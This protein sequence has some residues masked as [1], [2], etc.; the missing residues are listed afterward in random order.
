MFLVGSTI[1]HSAACTINDICDRDFDRQVGGW[2]PVSFNR[3][4]YQEQRRAHE[5]PPA[6]CWHHLRAWSYY[7]PHSSSR[8]VLLYSVTGEQYRVS[9]CVHQKVSS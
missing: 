6:C 1:L 9:S 4:R 2:I 5:E 8:C 3:F 7:I